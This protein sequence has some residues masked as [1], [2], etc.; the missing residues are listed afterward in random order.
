VTRKSRKQLKPA[1]EL[2]SPL[3][4]NFIA[5]LHPIRKDDS[6][7]GEIRML[8]TR[9]INNQFSL[10]RPMNRRFHNLENQFNQF[11]Y[12][13]NAPWS[14][15][16]WSYATPETDILELDDQYV[17]EIALPGVV[18][19][20]VELKVEY[21]TLMVVAKRTP[22]LFEEKAAVLRKELPAGY[23]VREF[24]F[25]T[26]ILH[27]QIEARM[28]RGILFVSIPKVESALRIPVM[29]G[30]IEGH[31][32]GMKTR[33]QKQESLSSRKEVSIK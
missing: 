11:G 13:S 1:P 6:T 2:D 18:L 20:D 5:R 23:L 21:N 12:E 19:D 33:V 3:W 10:R 15:N 28:D 31:L 4:L 9:T 22:V 17:L 30:S 14:C 16:N 29:A 26:E 24:E 7:G 32:P 25:E 27:E 8:Y